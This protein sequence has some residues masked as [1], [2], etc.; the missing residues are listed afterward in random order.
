MNSKYLG[1]NN[2]VNQLTTDSIQRSKIVAVAVAYAVAT[3]AA[4][5]SSPVDSASNQFSM[6]VL[7]EARNII[8]DFNENMVFDCRESVDAV[9]SF[10][11]MRYTAAHPLSTPL[12]SVER[13]FFENII[14]VETFV[15]PDFYEFVNKYKTEILRLYIV[16]AGIIADRGQ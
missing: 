1:F 11:L 16:A 7:P 10:W 9:R 12:F 3:M 15:S 13:S 6:S 8:S 5:P 2:A 4:L 14:G